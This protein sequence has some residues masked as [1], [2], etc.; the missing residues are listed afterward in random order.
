MHSMNYW[1]GPQACQS[2]PSVMSWIRSGSPIWKLALPQPC[3]HRIK[4]SRQ[5]FKCLFVGPC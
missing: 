3:S 2:L 5:G 4:R 1:A